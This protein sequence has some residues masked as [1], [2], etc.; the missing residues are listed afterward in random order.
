MHPWISSI[1]AGA[2][3]MLTSVRA[4]DSLRAMA[5]S[6]VRGLRAVPP[7][8]YHLFKSLTVSLT[9]MRIETSR[10]GAAMC[11]SLTKTSAPPSYTSPAKESRGG[12]LSRANRGCLLLV[13][14]KEIERRCRKLSNRFGGFVE[15]Q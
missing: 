9:K 2:V 4:S 11:S 7:I 5:G 14:G 3:A 8:L 10:E 12:A 6:G 1:D 13:P 15:V